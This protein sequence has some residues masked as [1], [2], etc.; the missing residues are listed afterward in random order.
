MPTWKVC[1]FPNNMH[2]ITSYLKALLEKKSAFEVGDEDE[3]KS[4]QKGLK[5]QIREGK[6][7][8]R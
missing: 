8:K 6:R 5:V 7:A 1:C 2:L 3:V 4:V